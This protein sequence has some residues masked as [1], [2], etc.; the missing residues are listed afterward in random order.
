MMTSP[1]AIPGSSVFFFT[2]VDPI[3]SSIPQVDLAKIV[4]E[5]F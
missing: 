1:M 2:N 4:V 3:D 5:F